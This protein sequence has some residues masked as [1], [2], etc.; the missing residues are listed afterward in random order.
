MMMNVSNKIPNDEA[1]NKR[2]ESQLHLGCGIKMA[3]ITNGGFGAINEMG[4]A[5]FQYT[6]EH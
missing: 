3:A 6:A 1:V 2:C 4:G 5:W